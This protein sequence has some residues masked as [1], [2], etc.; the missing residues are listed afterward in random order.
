[1]E[2]KNPVGRPTVMTE[3]AI[4]KLE[5]GFKKGFTD[6]EAC[7]NANISKDALYDYIKLNPEFSDRK[8]LLK[9]QP[10]MKAKEIIYSKLEENDDYNARWYLERK[11]K[12]EFSL[13]TEIDNKLSWELRMPDVSF[14]I[15]NPN[16]ENEERKNNW[17]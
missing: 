17:S 12:D 13:K 8:E 11:A 6:L 4:G 7:L 2:E 3:L 14:N 15:I 10:R 16:T 9:Q 1:M 5:D